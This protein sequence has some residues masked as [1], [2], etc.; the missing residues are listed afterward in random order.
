M[1][2]EERFRRVNDRDYGIVVGI[3]HYPGLGSLEGAQRDAESFAGWLVEPDG[4]G[5]PAGNVRTILTS[6]YHPP[7]PDRPAMADPNAQRFNAAIC[8]LLMD[9]AEVY[10]P[11]PI[12]RR[13]YLYFSGHGFQGSS[14]WEEAA[15]Y[16]ANATRIMPEHIPGT[17]V[18][19]AVKAAAAFEEIVLIMDCCRDVTLT[20]RISDPFLC[21]L[22]NAPQAAMVRTCFAYA[23]PRGSQA[24]E[25]QI[26]AG[27]PVQ[28]VF[29][30]TL[31]DAL[32]RAP[33]D[34][35]GKVTGQAIKNYIHN[36]WPD[37]APDDAGP[38]IEV[39]NVNDILFAV[40]PSA[41]S[42]QEGGAAPVQPQTQVFFSVDPPVPHGTRLVI[43]DGQL[44]EILR[45]PISGVAVSCFLAPGLY[46][47]C[48]DGA[49][50]DKYFQAVGAEIHERL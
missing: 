24:R 20:G 4:G 25:R 32:R 40:R 26:V 19:N 6:H 18:A 16:A 10:R 35:L 27:G 41:P 31:L 33:G 46:K 14:D 1:A 30:Y 13:L 8:D 2:V 48:L 43:L 7:F 23:V 50:R 5:L 42:D 28:G 29:T 15:L 38:R 47:A 36:M 44:R 12:G 22:P 11:L 39:D 37:V 9:G 21:L 34:G 45:L 3:D 49:G 17:R